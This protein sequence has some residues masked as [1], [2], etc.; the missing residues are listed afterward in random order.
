MDSMR[1]VAEEGY[2]LWWYFHF[3]Q[4]NTS[5]SAEMTSEKRD[6]KNLSFPATPTWPQ[7]ILD[8]QLFWNAHNCWA[9]SEFGVERNK[10]QPF[11]IARYAI[12]DDAIIAVGI[13][14]NGN[15]INNNYNMIKAKRTQRALDEKWSRLEVARK[16]L[17]TGNVTDGRCVLFKM[18][19]HMRDKEDDNH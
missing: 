19:A 13:S 8:R 10:S 1:S 14:T 16:G 11:K 4:I 12:Y 15:D 6:R 18:V 9:V 5:A 7:R 17:R 3:I 2:F